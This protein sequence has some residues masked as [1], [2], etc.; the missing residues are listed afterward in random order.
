M[1][2]KICIFVIMISSLLLIGVTNSTLVFAQDN[3]AITQRISGSDKYNTAVLIS[4]AGFT[5]A[6]TVIVVSS[7][8]YQDALIATSLSK[9]RNAP[10]LITKQSSLENVTINEIKRLKATKAFV[11]GN[12]GVIGSGVDKQ[13]KGLGI[14]VTRI[15]GVDRYDISKKIAQILG[16]QKGVVIAGNFDYSGLL[17]IATIASMKSMPILLSPKNSLSPKISALIKGRT[18]PVSYLIGG[19]SVLNVTIARSVP[20]SKRLSGTDIYNSNVN[21][22]N[23][24]SKDFNFNTVYLA[25]GEDF[26]EA[27]SAGALSTK[28]NSPIFLTQ[29]NTISKAT[30]NYMKSKKVKHVVILGGVGVISKSVEDMIKV[31]LENPMVNI[32]SVSLDKTLETINVGG[33]ATL[34]AI[35]SPSNATNKTLIWSS[36]NKNIVTVDS[37][38][39]ISTVT[40]GSAIIKVSTAD[41]NKIAS[42]V[43]T[44]INPVINVNRIDLDKTFVELPVGGTEI[45]KASITPD[46]ATNKYIGW[47]SS[48]NSIASID[49]IGNVMAVS[50]GSAIITVS[51]VDGKN[52]TSCAIT[53]IPEQTIPDPSVPVDSIPPAKAPLVFAI[54]IG[55]NAKY[56]SGANGIRNEDVCTKEVGT[57]VIEKLTALGYTVIDCSPTNSTSQTNAL[58]QRV[59]IANAAHADYFMSIHFNIFNGIASGSEVY[60]GSSRIKTKAQAVLNNLVGLGYVNRGLKDNSKGLYVLKNT[61]MPAMLVE[62]SFL[63][64]VDDMAIYDPE[65]IAQALVDGLI[66]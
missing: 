61:S 15:D 28:T 1:L 49:N 21:I 38:G 13:L 25:S 47:T 55:H 22:I 51:T 16:V 57:I 33:N 29:K 26:T 43:I 31:T 65:A 64:S 60:M 53:V 10:I 19:T 58:Q 24:F 17:S 27:L 5:Q 62:C 36:S 23:Q 44:V 3:K 2:K 12:Y 18:I 35:I 6:N 50:T 41:G 46:N 40:T 8:D 30:L 42:S 37:L 34:K 63:D 11:I 54:D 48:D 52:T 45:L 32:I 66:Y 4:K 7:Q 56:D 9:I 14:V 59:N 20:N 39:K